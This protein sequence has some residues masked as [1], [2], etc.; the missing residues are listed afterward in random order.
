MCM[1]YLI[2]EERHLYADRG[3]G[4]LQRHSLGTLAN[5]SQSALYVCLLVG[6]QTYS[7]IIHLMYTQF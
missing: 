6:K 1:T 2:Q 5:I 7:N 4:A 3:K